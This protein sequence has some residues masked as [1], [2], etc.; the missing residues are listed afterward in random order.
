M[1]APYYG[2]ADV[3]SIDDPLATITTKDRFG[4]CSP[5]VVPYGPR[6]EARDVAEPLP[7]IL[8]KDRLGVCTPTMEPFIGTARWGGPTDGLDTPLRTITTQREA[9]LVEPMVVPF[10]GPK[11]GQARMPRSIDEPIA[12][13]TT[14]PRFGVCVPTADPF[15]VPQFG[16]R[17]GQEP[18]VHPIDEPLPAVTGHGAGA[19]V[20]PVI[21]EPS[22]AVDPRRLVLIDG[23]TFVLDIRFRM[24]TN[25]ELARAMGFHDQET[26]YLFTG[27]TEEVT[28]QIGNAVACN[29]A[30]ALVT[31]ILE[32]G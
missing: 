29:T 23:Q 20:V 11:N 14:E 1:I 31:A 19:L 24:L 8:T 10:Y 32:E 25:R 3:D 18:R 12:T 15:I 13:I 17:V 9:F 16:E 30:A 4:L 26:E 5:V 22:E 21:G 28:R 2:R 7:T 6:A 27:N